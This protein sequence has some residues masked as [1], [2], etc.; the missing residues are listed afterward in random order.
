[1]VALHFKNA[2]DLN[3]HLGEFSIVRGTATSAVPAKPVIT[4]TKVLVSNH[5]GVD[6]KSFL[7]CL[8]TKAMRYVT[9]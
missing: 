2:K 4:T 9:I 1:M 8:T 7:K 3:L 6:G 5:S